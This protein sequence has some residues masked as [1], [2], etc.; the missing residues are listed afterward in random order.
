MACPRQIDSSSPEGIGQRQGV[1]TIGMRESLETRPH[2]QNRR[3][4]EGLLISLPDEQFAR[5]IDLNFH[6]RIDPPEIEGIPERVEVRSQSYYRPITDDGAC[7]FLSTVC[8]PLHSPLVE[9]AKTASRAQN[10]AIS[11]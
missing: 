10:R 6:S 5:V 8:H 1:A 4:E 11:L 3:R 9:A 7:V 2:R